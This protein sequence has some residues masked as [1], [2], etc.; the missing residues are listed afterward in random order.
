MF[1]TDL[2]FF[3]NF[4]ILDL[5]HSVSAFLSIF[6]IIGSYLDGSD[7]S[8]GPVRLANTGY[9]YGPVRLAYIMYIG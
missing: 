8:Y 2:L 7:Y 6:I 5:N 3:I 1:A 4:D 9:S